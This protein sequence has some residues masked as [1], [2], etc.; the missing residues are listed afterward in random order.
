MDTKRTQA[1]DYFKRY[2]ENTD[3]HITSDGRVWH[4]EGQ[5]KS[6]GMTL[7]DKTVTSF[8]RE[9]LDKEDAEKAENLEVVETTDE[10]DAPKGGQNPEEGKGIN[11]DESGKE[12]EKDPFAD[13]TLDNFDPAGKNAYAEGLA[14]VKR[15]NLETKSNKKEDILAA[16]AEAKAKQTIQ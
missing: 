2:P 16:V 12:D 13:L 8:N 14:L 10:S 15:L 7:K 3:C 5:A 9:T 4:E 6:F 1:L 11:P